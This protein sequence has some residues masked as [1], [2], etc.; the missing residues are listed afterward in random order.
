MGTSCYSGWSMGNPVYNNVVSTETTYDRAV[1][2]LF[3]RQ[4]LE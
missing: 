4:N 3:R 2:N 1:K